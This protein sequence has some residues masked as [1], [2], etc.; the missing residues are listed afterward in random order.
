MEDGIDKETYLVPLTLLRALSDLQEVAITSRVIKNEGSYF[1]IISKF[2]YES[3]WIGVEY[4]ISV[5]NPP[6]G[7]ACR[8]RI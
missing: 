1:W 2:V 6:S 4:W 5:Q 8:F 7:L 3:S